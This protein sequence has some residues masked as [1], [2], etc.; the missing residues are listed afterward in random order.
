MDQGD[1]LQGDGALARTHHSEHR[2][3]GLRCRPAEG[4]IGAAKLQDAPGFGV[5][6]RHLDQVCRQRDQ[7]CDLAVGRFEARLQGR[8]RGL[9]SFGRIG[10]VYEQFGLGQVGGRQEQGTGLP[11]HRQIH[12]AEAFA[13]VGDQQRQDRPLLGWIRQQIELEQVGGHPGAGVAAG[14]GAG[15]DP[16]QVHKGGRGLQLVQPFHQPGRQATQG[17]DVV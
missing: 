17:V 4:R 13:G 3:E 10:H 5:R 8:Q 14:V 12:V 11:L 1:P 15:D 2:H 7:V 16:L 6:R 9:D